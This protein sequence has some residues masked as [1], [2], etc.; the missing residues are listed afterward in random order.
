MSHIT[1]AEILAI[2]WTV[3]QREKQVSN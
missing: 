2:L 3:L 1:T